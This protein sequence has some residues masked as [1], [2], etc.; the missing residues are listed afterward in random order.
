MN[1]PYEMQA[2]HDGEC[3]ECGEDIL[4][5]DDIVWDP[6]EGKAYCMNCG[7]ELLDA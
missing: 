7:Q 3:S 1:E 4:E 6:H 5:G 2:K